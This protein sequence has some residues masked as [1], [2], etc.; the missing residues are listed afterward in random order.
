MFIQGEMCVK[1]KCTSNIVVLQSRPG[2]HNI[3]Y[4]LRKTSLFVADPC[5]S[6]LISFPMNMRIIVQKLSFPV[7]LKIISHSCTISPTKLKK[8]FFQNHAALYFIFSY[9]FLWHVS[10]AICSSLIVYLFII[11]WSFLV[12]APFQFS[13]NPLC[14]PQFPYCGTNK[15]LSHFI[16][17][18]SNNHRLVVAVFPLDSPTVLVM[19]LCVS[20]KKD[21][22]LC[23]YKWVEM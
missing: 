10:L 8:I 18:N 22:F 14:C 16:L 5:K 6:F 20:T 7:I 21:N 9:I 3:F 1:I 15:I 23:Y 4:W 2:P 19:W 17:S 11:Y 12:D 13:C